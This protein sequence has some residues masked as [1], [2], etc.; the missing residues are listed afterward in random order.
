MSKKKLLSIVNRL[1]KNNKVNKKLFSPVNHLNLYT[2]EKTFSKSRSLNKMKNNTVYNT[3][4]H[5]NL[6]TSNPS[7]LSI[8][9]YQKPGKSGHKKTPSNKDVGTS[10]TLSDGNSKGRSKGKDGNKFKA[11]PYKNIMPFVP[12]KSTKMLTLPDEPHF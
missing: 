3:N 10:M 7:Q 2:N 6:L 9:P 4:L 1:S 12:K 5:S 8:K 11:R